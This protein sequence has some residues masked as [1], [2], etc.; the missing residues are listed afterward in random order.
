MS[1]LKRVLI[2][3]T[4]SYI[5]LSVNKW[6]MKT[7]NE[8]YVETL[9]MKNQNWINYD[10]SQFDV[11]FHV[12]GIAHVSSKRNMK[13]LYSRVNRDLA[14]ETARK[15]KI[16]GVKQFI[17]MSSMIV[18]NSRES[19]ITVNTKPDPDNLYGTSKLQAEEGI[20]KLMS[21]DFNICIIRSPMIYGPNSKGNFPKLVNFAKK[22]L[23]FPNFKNIRSALYIDNLAMY[24]QKCID[25]NS[26]GVY[27]PQNNEYYSTSELV[28]SIRRHLNK[29]GY[30]PKYFNWLILFLRKYIPLFRKVFGDFYYD[31]STNFQ[32]QSVSFSESI[33]FSLKGTDIDA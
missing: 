9:D 12:A 32:F 29:K 8:F 31:I 20:M 18:Y 6:L 17:F 2:T 30:Y 24:I 5:G 27:F 4:N 1:D 28:V 25:S 19:K 22:T 10:F 21:K 33:I 23:L 14:I 16:S 26:N 13:E 3:G 11:V 15:A 7:P